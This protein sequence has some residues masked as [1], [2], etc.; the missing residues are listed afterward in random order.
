MDIISRGI[1]GIEIAEALVK[2]GKQVILI[3][4][5][6]YLLNKILDEDM[7]HYINDTVS[8][9]LLLKLN[10]ETL[11]INKG[12]RLVIT[13]KN[14]YEVDGTIVALG[15][16]PN[17]DLVKG[18]NFIGETKA[19]NTDQY[20]RTYMKEVYA[21]GDVAQSRNII[22]GKPD[23]QPFAPVAGKMRF[24][25]GNHIGGINYKFSGLVGTAI[26]KYKDYLIAKTGL[27]ENEAIKNGFKAI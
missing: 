22:T 5:N 16:E 26:T 8:K 15:V 19:I 12:G 17:T 23:W 11:E 10:E 25:A 3:H 9:D 18:N 7:A 21:V 20:M 1:L 27:T 13:N 2:N 24:T 4:K 14:K 6:P